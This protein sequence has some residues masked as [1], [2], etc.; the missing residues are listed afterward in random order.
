MLLRF[1]VSSAMAVSCSWFSACEGEA[2]NETDAP[3][4]P[5]GDASAV[6]YARK[7]SKKARAQPCPALARS[8]LWAARP[9]ASAALD[10]VSTRLLSFAAAADAAMIADYPRRDEALRLVERALRGLWPAAQLALF[11]SCATAMCLPGSDLDVVLALQSLPAAERDARALERA[12]PLLALQPWA[13]GLRCAASPV[14]LL[15]LRVAPRPGSPFVSVDVSLDV[16]GHL[17]EAATRLV[18]LLCARD[19]RLRPLALALK[20]LLRRAGL[21]SAHS[22]G[23]SSYQSVLLIAAFL[24]E[25]RTAY[26]SCRGPGADGVGRLFLDLLHFLG[27]GFDPGRV[28]VDLNALRCFQPRR[29]AAADGAALYIR[30]PV[31]AGGAAAAE[32]VARGCFRVA[33]VQRALAAASASLDALAAGGRCGE[34][35]AAM[36][37]LLGL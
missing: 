4:N 1:D 33:D 3:D 2:V 32:N 27:L 6:N 24:K 11:G 22:G 37:A 16:P 29:G 7:R 35:D 30:N 5:T 18:R 17:G 12:L 25:A 13:S 20:A 23:L 10:V 9:A 36:V 34:V 21:N 15:S 28:G 26:G 19:W 14:P 8:A 31:V